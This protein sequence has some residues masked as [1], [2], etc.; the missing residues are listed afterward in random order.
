MV[1]RHL[2]DFEIKRVWAL[3]G[4]TPRDLG[5]DQFFRPIDQVKLLIALNAHH[6]AVGLVLDAPR[7]VAVGEVSL[8]E[9]HEKLE[10]AFLHI[11]FELAE[12]H[13]IVAAEA[14]L[15]FAR[16][17]NDLEN[18]VYFQRLR[19]QHLA[20]RVHIDDVYVAEVLPED[21]KLLFCAPLLILKDLDIID[22]LLQLFVVFL[23]KGV[24]IEDEK[25]AIVAAD[26]SQILV[27]STAE[28]PVATRLLHDDGAQLLI[29][30]MELVALPARKN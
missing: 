4:N 9:R 8:C 17:H 7:N 26:P 29:I 30:H 1:P 20:H 27:D 2:K 12:E 21:D 10:R 11:F 28:K 15:A 16:S 24:D 18:S 6:E 5:S 23:L 22:T 19:L 3:L 13:T 14:D 25:V